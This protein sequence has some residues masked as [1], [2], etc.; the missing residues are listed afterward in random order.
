M[1]QNN[2]AQRNA[3]ESFVYVPPLHPWLQF[4]L[5]KGN[6][7]VLS[8]LTR[9]WGD[10]RRLM[11]LLDLM[12]KR[13]V[14]TAAAAKAQHL[15]PYKLPQVSWRQIYA[16]N[17]F[18]IEYMTQIRWDLMKWMRWGRRMWPRDAKGQKNAVFEIAPRF[19]RGDAILGPNRQFLDKIIE[20]LCVKS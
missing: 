18:N 2:A 1:H 17:E 12:Q 7:H 9:S 15:H 5:S 19:T 16:L 8:Q 10:R 6:W 11:V 4:C 20:E 3:N 13:S 14:R